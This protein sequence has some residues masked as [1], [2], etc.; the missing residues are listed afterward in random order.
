VTLRYDAALLS[1]FQILSARK[2]DAMRAI[3]IGAGRGS[4][5]MPTTADSPKCFAEVGGMRILDWALE[6]LRQNGVTDV[7]FIGG[8]QIEKVKAAYPDFTIL[9]GSR[10][11]SWRRSSSPKTSWTGRSF[12]VTPIFCI[13]LR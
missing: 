8:Y 12:A 6:A 11:T 1:L 13:G 7:A 3:I 5:L 10:T 2:I 9:R 4:R